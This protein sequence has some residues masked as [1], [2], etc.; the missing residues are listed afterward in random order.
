LEV[1]LSTPT[2]S[3]CQT[4]TDFDGKY[5]PIIGQAIGHGCVYPVD[6]PTLPDQLTAAG[7]TW[8]SYSEDMGSDP[9]R[10]SPTCGHPIIGQPDATQRAQKRDGSHPQDQYAARHNPFVYFHSIIDLPSCDAPDS[11]C[12][13]R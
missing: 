8:K 1:N 12:E 10:E 5:N 11:D 9:N 4:Y 6:V 7:F 3:D 2:Q 13:C